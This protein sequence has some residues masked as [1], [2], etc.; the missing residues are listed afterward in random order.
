VLRGTLIAKRLTPPA[1]RGN[2]SFL[3]EEEGSE[4]FFRNLKLHRIQ[5]YPARR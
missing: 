4:I 2:L 3:L 5:K 1:A